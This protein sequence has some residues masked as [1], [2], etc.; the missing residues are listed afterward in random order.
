MSVKKP[1]QEE[2][3]PEGILLREMLDAQID[4]KVEDEFVDAEAFFKK[5]REE[6][7]ER[8]A[9]FSEWVEDIAQQSDPESSY[10]DDDPL[11]PAAQME[12]R[13]DQLEQNET[14]TELTA[15]FDEVSEADAVEPERERKEEKVENAERPLQH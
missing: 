10:I 11:E 13:R 14:P 3:S 6:E 4:S 7:Q 2:A 1:I 9:D 15:D 5:S 12:A 8:I